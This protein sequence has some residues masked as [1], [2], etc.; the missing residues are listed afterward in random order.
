MA[1]EKARTD[2]PDGGDN[3]SGGRGRAKRILT[4]IAPHSWEHP[5]DKAALQAL[6]R[7]PVFDDI[8]KKIFGFFGEK[9]IRLA[10]QANAVRVSPNQFGHIYSMYK[11]CLKTLDAPE[12]YPL[13]MSQTPMVNAGAY[14]MDQP[15]IILNS[16][17]VRLLEDDELSYVISHEIGH[18]MSDHVLYK[19]MTV[20]LIN[21]ANMGFPIV[22]LAAR[23]VLVGLLEWSRKSELSSDRAG[24]LGVQDPEVVMRTMLKMA[25]GGSNEETSLQE[26]II[27]AEEYQEGGDVADQVF[28]VL[29]LM[30]QTHPFYVL[31]VS[32]LRAWIETGDYDRIVRGEYARRGEADPAYQEDLKEAA[33][34]YADGAKEFLD[35]MA[36]AAKRAGSDFLSGFKR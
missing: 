12:E 31:R 16:G 23:A 11:E 19:T 24:L 13:F 32:E 5:A 4:D 14:G 30:F 7:I 33:T 35:T 27:Q 17:T 3:K 10:F 34:A 26:F 28:K 18:I 9:P 22:G 2:E 20:L 29:N 15:F 36:D 1:D 8:L 25:G 6:R 21:L